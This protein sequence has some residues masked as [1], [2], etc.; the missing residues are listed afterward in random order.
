M[1]PKELFDILVCPKDHA[2]LI[3]TSDRTGLKCTKCGTVYPIEE[4]V[5]SFL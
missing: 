4:G 1:I 2:P 3:Y 5:P